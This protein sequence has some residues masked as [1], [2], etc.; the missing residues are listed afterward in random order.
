MVSVLYDC[1]TLLLNYSTLLYLMCIVVSAPQGFMAGN[2]GTEDN[3]RYL[4]SLVC[5]SFR[6]NDHF[7]SVFKPRKIETQIKCFT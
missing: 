4:T 7:Y 3:V 2:K 1:N 6:M 5:F